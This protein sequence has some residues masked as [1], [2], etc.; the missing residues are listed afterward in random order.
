MAVTYS[1]SIP[2]QHRWRSQAV[3]KKIYPPCTACTETPKAS[4]QQYTE[5]KATPDNPSSPLS[6]ISEASRGSKHTLS[7][8]T[9]RIN[10]CDY[11]TPRA[12]QQ[13][14]SRGRDPS[15]VVPSMQEPQPRSFTTQSSSQISTSQSQPSVTGSIGRAPKLKRNQRNHDGDVA[16]EQTP[17]ATRVSLPLLPP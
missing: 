8:Q 4:H 6:R 14:P 12:T 9:D 13:Q 7:A 1:G 15:M 2:N 11:E 5:E 17:P 16:R 10:S 3:T